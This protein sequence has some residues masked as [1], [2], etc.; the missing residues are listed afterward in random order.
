MNCPISGQPCNKGK[1]VHFTQLVGNKKTEDMVCSDCVALKNSMGNLFGSFENLFSMSGKSLPMVEGGNPVLDLFQNLFGGNYP[2]NNAMHQSVVCTGCNL[3]LNQI[4]QIGRLG[5]DKCYESFRE[6]LEP[7]IQR[8]HEN[9][10]HHVGKKPKNQKTFHHHNLEDLK[11][12]LKSA[13]KEERFEDA[14]VLRDAIKRL[15]EHIKEDPSR[16][17]D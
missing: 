17:Q 16:Q 11:N 2:P 15:E 8:S 6:Y 1:H 14:T 7:V 3:S 10:L 4:R 9:N 13:V 12:K 5:C